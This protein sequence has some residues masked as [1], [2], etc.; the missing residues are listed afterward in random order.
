[1]LGN[2]RNLAYA[3]ALGCGTYIGDEHMYDEVLGVCDKAIDL[4]RGR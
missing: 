3:L 4:A 1:M 2:D